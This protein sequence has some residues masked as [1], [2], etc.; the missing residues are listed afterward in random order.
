MIR[1]ALVF[2][3]AM[4]GSNMR[5]RMM[6]LAYIAFT[7]TAVNADN[8]SSLEWS[9]YLGG[10]LIDSGSAVVVGQ[11]GI[12]VVAGY[13]SSDS[14]PVS[15]ES[16][17]WQHGGEKDGFVAAF[18]PT[19]EIMLWSTYLGGSE[20]DEVVR[21]A[22]SG[23]GDLLVLSSTYSAD[24]P[25][26]Y[27]AYDTEFSGPTD[28]GLS[29]F[30]I[31]TGEIVW[32]TYVGTVSQPTEGL[33]VDGEG[34]IYILFRG[35]NYLHRF[36]PSG[37]YDRDL[38]IPTPSYT[39]TE[40]ISICHDGNIILVGDTNNPNYPVTDGA[41]DTVYDGGPINYNNDGYVTKLDTESGEIIWSTFIGGANSVD[42][43]LSACVDMNDNVIIT[44]WT[45]S[46][47]YPVTS[48]AIDTSSGSRA[49]MVSKFSADGAEL[50][51][52][53][54]LSGQE[55]GHGEQVLCDETDNVYIF[56]WTASS[57]MPV[58][59]N[60]YD[61]TYNGDVDAY[62]AKLSA[63]G[64]ALYYGTYLG[65]ATNDYGTLRDAFYAGALSAEGVIGIG[66]TYCSDYPGVEYGYDSINN[67]GGDVVFSLISELGEYPTIGDVQDDQGGFVTVS[68]G[69]F[70]T[71]PQSVS[72]AIEYYHLEQYAGG[73]I[74]A[75]SLATDGLATYSSTV[76][77][78]AVLIVGEDP[79]LENYRVVGYSNGGEYRYYSATISGYSI[80]NIPPPPPEIE[81]SE[82]PSFRAILWT[83]PELDDYEETC[84]YRD[85]DPDFVPGPDSLILCTTAQ[86]Y[87]EDHLQLYYYRAQ[88]RDTHG[89]F[90]EP[91]NQVQSSYPTDIV[92]SAPELSLH[93]N[94]PNPFN[95]R[96]V[97]SYS[98]QKNTSVS[99]RIYDIFG[100]EIRCLI[101]DEA[102]SSGHYT[103]EWNGQDD[104]GK[105][106]AAGVYF[107]SLDAWP[108]RETKRM[109][110]V[111]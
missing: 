42:E 13:M 69:R 111:K 26:T 23:T 83:N 110:L 22:L 44:G 87:V 93:Q 103:V 64:R 52:S 50:I 61:T 11:S 54:F 107:Y 73:W 53:T 16:F 66:H 89:N 71:Y 63:N 15:N 35:R 62:V 88:F 94:Y 25:T 76:G 5:I 55:T 70:P 75:D 100:H 46:S 77:T 48:G 8:P 82:S 60:A 24:Y 59:D 108:I 47:D 2:T 33:A 57:D 32:S 84:L 38:T 1:S 72:D 104:M 80:D 102:Q 43:P 12:I 56:G 105:Q 90:S 28:N 51:W 91:S 49:T 65:G 9:S 21:L 96:T 7:C 99:L 18:D 30:D 98:L 14:L 41:Y 97:I 31:V 68:W 10:N 17:Q 67:G 29:L 95:P 6:I 58:T 79:D 3:P 109:T 92:A 40:N 34:N 27:G 78:D 45:L 106:M 86:F 19:G 85:D 20:N 101:C 39:Y 4:L 37:Y 74:V 36:T 81:I